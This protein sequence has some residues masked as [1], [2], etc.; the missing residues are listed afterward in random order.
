MARDPVNVF[1]PRDTRRGMEFKYLSSEIFGTGGTAVTASGTT[2]IPIASPRMEGWVNAI[3]IQ[4]TTAAVSA[5]GTVL[6]TVYKWNAAGAAA[7]A[8][9][10]PFSIEAAG[11]TAL[12]NALDIPVLSTLTDAQRTK[13]P[14]DTFY[15]E[16]VSDAA[17]GTAPVRCQVTIELAQTR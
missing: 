6:V 14:A 11:L 10:T 12:Q 7:V 16:I 15:L 2:T 3:S 9:N 8:L 17:I 4:G 5:S 1:R 13:L